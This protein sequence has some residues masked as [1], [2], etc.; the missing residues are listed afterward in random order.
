M[1]TIN[2]I[3]RNRKERRGELVSYHPLYSIF[4]KIV[5]DSN[6]RVYDQ[7]DQAFLDFA[8]YFLGQAKMYKRNY[9]MEKYEEAINYFNKNGYLD[10]LTAAII[11][12]YIEQE[13]NGP[14]NDLTG[15][16]IKK[17]NEKHL[18]D[19]LLER[20]LFKDYGFAFSLGL[21]YNISKDQSI[22]N[23]IRTLANNLSDTTDDMKY[24]LLYFYYSRLISEDA[25][26]DEEK[27]K[28]EMLS[29][30]LLNS[31]PKSKSWL[32][33]IPALLFIDNP[34]AYFKDIDASIVDP[35][36][37]Y[38]AYTGIIRFD[39][40]NNLKFNISPIH[41][42]NVILVFKR[43]NWDELLYI[44]PAEKNEFKKFLELK[45]ENKGIYDKWDSILLAIFWASLMTLFLSILLYLIYIIN[46]ALFK[47]F[48]SQ[49]LGVPS[50]I[51]TLASRII[52]TFRRGKK[53][54]SKE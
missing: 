25:L 32:I 21:L 50:F 54:R 8:S 22:Y 37:Y 11:Y 51:L 41:I 46:P 9:F 35:E 1:P 42:M 12:L 31:D 36:F 43:L 5:S 2:I 38:S 15:S 13:Y 30:M 18:L 27:N 48:L 39:E 52:E 49:V 47:P 45:T 44:S 40:E 19:F 28:A 53:Y 20:S 14:K 6:T 16:L 3:S 33:L 17:I 34:A 4:K 29:K 24:F 7:P 10:N 23:F 26:S